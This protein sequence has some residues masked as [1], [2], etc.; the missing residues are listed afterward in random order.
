[1]LERGEEALRLVLLRAAAAA[2]AALALAGA[3]LAADG[4]SAKL[5]AAMK[6][7][8]AATYANGYVFSR[9]TCAIPSTTA[10]RASCNAYF[11]LQRQR[12]KG[13][14]RLA[15]TIDR[16]TGGVRWR[17]TSASCTDLKS[18]AKVRC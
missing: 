5:A 10:T 14:F 11:T 13:V 16:S 15:I 6:R 17:A 3:A 4:Q 7:S 2:L 8:V 12:L 9:V 1:V 18:G